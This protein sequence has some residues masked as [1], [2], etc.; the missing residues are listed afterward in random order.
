MEWQTAK[1][2]RV[3]IVDTDWNLGIKL[4]DWLAA[5]GYQPVLHRSYNAALAEVNSI[6]PE[7]IIIAVDSCSLPG[8]VDVSQLLFRLQTV[9]PDL[10]VIGI[11]DT[12]SESVTLFG[13]H[14]DVHL[15]VKPVDFLEVERLLRSRQC[16]ATV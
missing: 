3:M 6:R 11:A 7:A 4:A 10:P 15:L 13:D 14:S 2:I 8:Q 9:C 16:L 12:T 5:R 1:R